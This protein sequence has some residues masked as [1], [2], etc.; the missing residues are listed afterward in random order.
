M[1]SKIVET[2]RE[3]KATPLWIWNCLHCRNEQQTEFDPNALN[4]TWDALCPYCQE[5]RKES[6]YQDFHSP[7]LG[8]RVVKIER[9]KSQ[10]YRVHAAWNLT[11]LRGERR[12]LVTAEDDTLIIQPIG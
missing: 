2:H 4:N 12:W 6:E 1:T 3:T 9:P 7:M 5:A 8:G 10:E 11:I